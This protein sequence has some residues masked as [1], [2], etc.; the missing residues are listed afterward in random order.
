MENVG[1]SMFRLL[2]CNSE[3]TVIMSPCALT[4]A[5]SLCLKMWDKT[6]VC[7]DFEGSISECSQDFVYKCFFVYPLTT[8][9]SAPSRE[10][11]IGLTSYGGLFTLFANSRRYHQCVNLAVSYMREIFGKTI[12]TTLVTGCSNLGLIQPCQSNIQV[13]SLVLGKIYRDFKC[14]RHK[15]HLVCYNYISTNLKI[16]REHRALCLPTTDPSVC[17]IVI[18]SQDLDLMCESKLMK[19]EADMKEELITC[20]LP[21]IYMETTNQ[22]SQLLSPLGFHHTHKVLDTYTQIMYTSISYPHQDVVLQSKPNRQPD[23][24]L[25]SPF[26]FYTRNRLDQSIQT[27]GRVCCDLPSGIPSFFPANMK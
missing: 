26:F 25:D 19:I 1:L 11:L 5:L 24:L 13:K 21:Y 20:Y 14:H 18:H 10:L 17:L 7:E 3:K 16:H 23:F 9:M 15:K 2:V 27:C 6:V 22:L 4:S 8:C 12:D